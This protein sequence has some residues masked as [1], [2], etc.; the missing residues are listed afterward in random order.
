[1]KKL[2]S[3]QSVI[4]SDLSDVKRVILV[5]NDLAEASVFRTANLVGVLRTTVSRIITVYIDLSKMSSEKHSI[6]RKSKVKTHDSQLLKRIVTPK[7]KTTLPQITS[8]M[9]THLQNPV[10]MEIILLQLHAANFHGKVAITKPF[11]NAMK[12]LQ[13]AETS[14][15]EHNC[16]G[17]QVSHLV[18]LFLI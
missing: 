7:R 8:E 3:L 16:N 5:G 12:R 2:C 4:I 15:T 18:C 9:N 17:K 1:M 11:V 13:G 14:E 10:S 6:G